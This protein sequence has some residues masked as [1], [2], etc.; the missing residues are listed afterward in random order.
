MPVWQMTWHTALHGWKSWHK[1]ESF[2]FTYGFIALNAKAQ[3]R[4]RP[5]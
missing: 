4:K 2:C 1:N 5:P 3:S